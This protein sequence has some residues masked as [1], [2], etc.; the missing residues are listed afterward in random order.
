M[1]LS[2]SCQCL[3]HSRCLIKYLNNERINS[4]FYESA[5]RR[6]VGHGALGQGG[7]GRGLRGY[8]FGMHASRLLPCCPLKGCILVS[9]RGVLSTRGVHSK[10]HCTSHTPQFSRAF[11]L[12]RQHGDSTE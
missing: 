10:E 8:C 3:A 1:L 7:L 6:R 12:P 5:M 11:L 9:A 4:P 2:I